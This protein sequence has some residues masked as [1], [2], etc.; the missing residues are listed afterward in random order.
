MTE[1]TQAEIVE[2]MVEHSMTDVETQ[3]RQVLASKGITATQDEI[4]HK[5][6][7]LRYQLAAEYADSVEA[8]RGLG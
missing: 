3:L 8:A 1:P 5:L 6:A 4:D 7:P 2:A